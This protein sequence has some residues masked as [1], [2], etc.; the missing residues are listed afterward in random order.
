MSLCLSHLFLLYVAFLFVIAFF[1]PHLD[2]DSSVIPNYTSCSTSYII[3]KAFMR[4]RPCLPLL[5]C[6][7][8]LQ[9][10][11]AV[12]PSPPTLEIQIPVSSLTIIVIPIFVSL[13]SS[14]L[15]LFFQLSAAAVTA[16][17]E[18][19]P[20]AGRWVRAHR[21][22]D[23]RRLLHTVKHQWLAHPDRLRCFFPGLGKGDIL[24][25]V[26]LRCQGNEPPALLLLP[27]QP[28]PQRGNLRGHPERIQVRGTSG[29]VTPDG[30]RKEL[31]K[32]GNRQEICADVLQSFL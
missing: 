25:C 23:I 20:G 11:I 14:H 1:L 19:E 27:Q 5:L 28:L 9:M 29:V 18:C 21:L 31:L 16:A 7:L 12:Y 2:C 26:W 22:H 17:C 3:L 24:G 30:G 4:I 13:I 6:L 10:Y 8:S 32:D 15:L